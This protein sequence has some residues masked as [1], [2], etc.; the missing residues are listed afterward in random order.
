MVM[1]DL[2]RRK[3][4]A[5][6]ILR[7]KNYEVG[8]FLGNGAFGVVYKCRKSDGTLVAAKVTFGLWDSA[9]VLEEVKAAEELRS[10]KP[11]DWKRIESE[12]GF[13]S[14]KLERL[15]KKS[16]SYNKYL[17][18]PVYVGSDTV[19]GEQ[20]AIFEA[21]LADDSL[22]GTVD[23]G[24]ANE[25]ATLK[26]IARQT[27]KAL[28]ILH[29]HDRL[30]LDIKPDNILKITSEK[31]KDRFQLADF[32]L[33]TP[34]L[35]NDGTYKLDTAAIGDQY[36]KAPEIRSRSA[37]KVTLNELKAVDIYAVGI[38][39][40]QLYCEANKFNGPTCNACFEMLEEKSHLIDTL[41]WLPDDGKNFLKLVSKMI[42][43]D[44]KQ[45]PTAVQALADS[46][47]SK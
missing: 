20:I 10:M 17:N 41:R 8:D 11:F 37:A 5:M 14:G 13:L 38:T 1:E 28:K 3:V 19:E 27:L 33:V 31:G 43:L 25:F 42:S 44:P 35:G 30:H 9:Q 21:P 2:E 40:F 45:R 32:G 15:K 39:L 16:S 22:F 18:K 46:G 7:N 26:K 36:Y 23:L 4:E 24:K 12:F 6:R 34:A 47:L 29:D